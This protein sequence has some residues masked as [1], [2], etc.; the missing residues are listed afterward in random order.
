MYLKNVSPL[1]PLET[2]ERTRTKKKERILKQ[3][4]LFSQR[5]PSQD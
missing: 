1:V 2:K 5:L 4:K 3:R